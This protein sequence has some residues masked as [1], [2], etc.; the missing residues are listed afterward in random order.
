[1]NFRA[2]CDVKLGLECLDRVSDILAQASK[3]RLGE[4]IR[5]ARLVVREHLTQASVIRLS[6][7]FTLAKASSPSEFSAVCVCCLYALMRTWI[8]RCGAMSR[9]VCS[10]LTFERCHV[11]GDLWLMEEGP[12]AGRFIEAGPREGRRL[13]ISG[14]FWGSRGGTAWQHGLG[15][16]A[17]HSFGNSSEDCR[18]WARRRQTGKFLGVLIRWNKFWVAQKSYAPLGDTGLATKHHRRGSYLDVI[19]G[20][21][22]W[23]NSMASGVHIICRRHMIEL[24]ALLG[25]TMT[26]QWNCWGETVMVCEP[27][28]DSGDSESNLHAWRLA[29]ESVPPGDRCRAMRDEALYA[30]R[31]VSP[32]RRFG[33]GSAWHYVPYAS[34]FLLPNKLDKHDDP[35]RPDDPDGPKDPNEPDDPDKTDD[36]NGANDPDGPDNPNGPD[37]LDEPD[38]QD[39]PED[40]DEPDD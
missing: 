14:E 33:G 29:A 6:E 22:M 40:P 8:W 30:W 25:C 11:R 16:Q 24:G 28:G 32:A 26:W 36:W 21:V 35:N 2:I 10:V 15:R 7:H 1:M 12:R 39:R 19:A 34:R 37:D 23:F 4:N 31:Y 38:D 13:I 20:V 27:P 9:F 5:N 18:K 17:T 3:A